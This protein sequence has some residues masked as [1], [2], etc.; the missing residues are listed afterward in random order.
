MPAMLEITAAM[1]EKT[2]R[3]SSRY[4]FSRMSPMLR[5]RGEGIR[6]RKNGSG[7]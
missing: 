1:M 7:K 2:G 5:V 3:V 6:A 4:K